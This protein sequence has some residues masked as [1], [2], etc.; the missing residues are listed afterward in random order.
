M[1]QNTQHSVKENHI[2][3][4]SHKYVCDAHMWVYCYLCVLDSDIEHISDGGAQLK[5]IGKDNVW[6]KNKEHSQAVVACLKN[7]VLDLKK[8]GWAFVFG[9]YLLCA[10]Y[11]P[12]MLFSCSKYQIWDLTKLIKSTGWYLLFLIHLVSQRKNG[13]YL[14]WLWNSR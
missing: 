5:K 13:T 12:E 3:V 8:K 4:S 11:R 9:D 2:L 14:Q 6:Q 10:T 7:S 1:T